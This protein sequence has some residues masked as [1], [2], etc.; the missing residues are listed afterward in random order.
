VCNS[1]S[2]ADGVCI[3]HTVSLACSIFFPPPSWSQMHGGF[4]VISW[5]GVSSTISSNIPQQRKF[6]LLL[7][8]EKFQHGVRWLLVCIRRFCV[9]ASLWGFLKK[10]SLRII[11]NDYGSEWRRLRWVGRVVSMRRRLM[12]TEL[13]R[14]TWNWE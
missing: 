2:R 13:G 10:K 3:L 9:A 12:H 5:P 1:S 6:L 7:F 8:R 11:W 4:D 14:K